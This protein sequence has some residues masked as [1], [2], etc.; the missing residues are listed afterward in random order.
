MHTNNTNRDLV[1]VIVPFIYSLFSYVVFMNGGGGDG[2]CTYYYYYLFI[3]NM[4][5]Y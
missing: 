3:Q 2:E 1:D 5:D 4:K